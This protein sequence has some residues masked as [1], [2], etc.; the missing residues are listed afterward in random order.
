MRTHYDRCKGLSLNEIK[1]AFPEEIEEIVPR[2]IKELEEEI[3]DYKEKRNIR[4]N[5]S[6][7]YFTPEYARQLAEEEMPK[8]KVNHMNKLKVQINVTN[9][10]N[11]A[12]S[13]AEIQTAKGK[14]IRKLHTFNKPRVY[15]TRF[16]ACCPFHAGGNEKTPSFMINQRNLF[17]CFG[18]GEAGDAITFIMKLNN[19]N[20]IDA[21][22][23]LNKI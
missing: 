6:L 23:F 15:G 12:V 5:K 4:F 20:F 3:N 21:V 22:K 19:L 16:T 1:E 13:E 7:N 2:V 10:Y 18:C 17:K 14:D 8:E 9:G 11:N